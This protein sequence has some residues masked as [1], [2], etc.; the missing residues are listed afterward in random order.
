MPAADIATPTL[1]IV[2]PNA[3]GHR[4]YYVKVLADAVMA[5][6][7]GRVEW[8]TSAQAAT[9]SQA[10]V[11]LNALVSS[12]RLG[13]RVLEPWPDRS[14][15]LGEVTTNE[16]RDVVCLPDGDTWLPSVASA[17]AR[18]KL[19]ARTN[20]ITVLCLRPPARGAYGTGG[21]R[22]LHHVAKTGLLTAIRVLAR[23]AGARISVLGL[24]DA[25]GCATTRLAAGVRPVRD[26][27]TPRL[28]A[29]RAAARATHG[30]PED[31]FVVGLLGA[32]N[33]R[34]NP[35]IVAR[36]C[37]AVFADRPGR[38][39]VMGKIAPEARAALNAAGLP[40]HQLDVQDRYVDEVELTTASAVC[41][42]LALVYDNAQSA[43]GI[44]ALA[45]QTGTAVL[46]PVGTTL[47]AVA[48]GEG[49]GVAT[50]PDELSIAR[51]L[52]IVIAESLRL[53]EGAAR[54]RACLGTDDF[55]SALAADLAPVNG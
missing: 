4:L 22:R 54:A 44:A 46:V 21:A 6:G 25:F 16:P 5:C 27:I 12:G 15:V 14:A 18:R 31:E 26:P 39:L 51:A 3:S 47:E 20:T 1:R 38:L 35:G 30:I 11:Q 40:Q 28:P 9:S 53:S 48:V 33:A 23:T 10:Q 55:T 43:S 36:G 49:F 37:A 45:A 52:G 50:R 17:V 24:V 42:V 32:V 19:G 41:D 8:I 13:V 29:T 7:R 34:K 2:E